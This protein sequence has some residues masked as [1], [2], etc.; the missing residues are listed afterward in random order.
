MNKII[1]K[2]MLCGD[3]DYYSLSETE[4]TVY[5]AKSILKAVNN[6]T[7]LEYYKSVCGGYACDAVDQMYS[8]G[9]DEIAAVIESANAIFPESCPPEDSEERLDIISDFE[10]EFE[11][12]FDEWTD[13]ILEFSSML[14]DEIQAIISSADFD[15]Q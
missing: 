6:G 1:Q 15:E 8:I 7:L 9:M 4:K 3:D 5:N 2:I 13:E 10:Y 14:E 11:S 12:L